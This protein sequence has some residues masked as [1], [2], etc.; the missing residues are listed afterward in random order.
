VRPPSDPGAAAA[1]VLAGL[2]ALGLHAGCA[3]A[4]K[5]KLA[6]AP[7]ALADEAEALMAKKKYY[8]ARMLLQQALEAGVSDK[9]LNA[10]LQIALADTYFLDGGTLNLGEALSRYTNF[11]AFNPLHPRADYVQYQIGR[12]HFLQV[13]SAD[14][15]Q[16]QT[17]KAIEEFRKVGALYPASPYVAQAEEGIR[18]ASALLA[19]HEIEVGRFYSSRRA[20]AAA[21][22]RYKVALDDYPAYPDKPRVYYLLAEALAGLGRAEEARAYLRLLLENYPEH[23]MIPPARSLLHKVERKFPA[24]AGV[25]SAAE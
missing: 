10:R 1:L 20:W 19:E 4:G 13:Y 15:D 16:A 25:G 11:L 8:R 3:S 7:A 9:D 2:L 23:E 21:I 24:V 14:K 5:D 6:P 22:D 12:C 18:Q 17:R